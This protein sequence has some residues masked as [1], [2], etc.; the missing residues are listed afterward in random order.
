PV[1]G[2]LG[3]A[4]AFAEIDEVEDVLLE[5]GAAEADGGLEEL[6]ADAGVL[7]DGVGDLVNVGAG[8]LAEGGDGVDRGDALRE[9]GV[10]DEFGEL[11]GPEVGGDDALAGDPAGIDRGEG[12]DGGVALGGAFAA[13]EHAVGVEQV[14]DG[15]ALGEELGVGEDLADAAVAV[16]LDDLLDGL[17]GLYRDGGLFDDDL[18]G[19]GDLGDGPGHGLDVAQIGGAAGTDAVGFGGGVD[20]DEDDVGGGD[21]GLDVGGEEEVFPAGLFDDV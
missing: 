8:G 3:Q 4:E 20:R 14:G 11:G 5:A 12:L 6:G 9:E 7:A 21:G 15:G 2:D 10:G 16:G 17:G 1:G 13:D 18:G 19:G